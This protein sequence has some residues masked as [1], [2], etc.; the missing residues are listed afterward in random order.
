MSA[1]ASASVASVMTLENDKRPGPV[2]AGQRCLRAKAIY[3]DTIFDDQPV[4][5]DAPPKL[6]VTT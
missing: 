6:G 1:R 5:D 2:L 3:I 4:P